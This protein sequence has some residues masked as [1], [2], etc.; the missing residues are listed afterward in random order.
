MSIAHLTA[1]ERETVV[2][3]DDG[4]DTV[5]IGTAL[6]MVITR[7]RRDP[8][9]TEV[10]SGSHGSTPWAEFT[11]PA[12]NWSPA[13]VRRTRRPSA[14]Q[15]ANL[16]LGRTTASEVSEARKARPELVEVSA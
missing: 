3:A 4:N 7:L 8:A 11:I 1:D 10:A 15:L 12:A 2:N 5:R 13:G 9:F 6:A 16:A 14:A